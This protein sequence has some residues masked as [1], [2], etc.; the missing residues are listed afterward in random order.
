VRFVAI[1]GA[2]GVSAALA[3]E[4]RPAGPAAPAPD[5]VEAARAA[6]QFNTLLKALEAAGLLET[7]KGPGPYT[8]F[9]PTDEAFSKLPKE[10]LDALLANRE[11]LKAVLTYH[12]VPGKLSS[13][14]VAK[15]QALK[16]LQ[17]DELTVD[18]ASGS[19]LVDGAKVV[20]ADIAASNG[21]LHGID[22]VLLEEGEGGEDE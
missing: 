13:S 16:T 3:Q 21:M 17:G 7:L 9:A 15:T 6:G 10:E 2:L 14:D 8:V 4:T 1:L 5:L 18:A 19:V 22:I 20:Q 12:V 11:D